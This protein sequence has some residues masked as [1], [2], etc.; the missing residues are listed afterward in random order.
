MTA[1]DGGPL[2]KGLCVQTKG[3]KAVLSQPCLRPLSTGVLLSGSSFKDAAALNL[4][5]YRNMNSWLFFFFA[6]GQGLE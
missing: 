1:E 4:W 5:Y 3:E 2:L 6:M